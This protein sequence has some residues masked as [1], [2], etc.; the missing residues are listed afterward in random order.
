MKTILLA[1]VTAN[2]F[3]A[4]STN[5]LA[6]WTSKEDKKL[7]VEETKKAGVMIMGRTT[8][9]TIGKPLPGRLIIVLTEKPEEVAVV[10][11]SV[12]TASGDLK[13]ILENLEKRGY[14]SVIVAGGSNVYSQFLNAGLVDELLLT[15]EAVMFTDGI[16]LTQ[17]LTREIT[18]ELLSVEKLGE[19]SVLFRYS[20]HLSTSPR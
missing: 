2:G 10:P 5:E 3:I 9:A 13:M 8:F 7:F 17:N 15:V 20:T 1:A 19:K 18:L 12:E 16:R 14:S 4:R 11:G 6:N